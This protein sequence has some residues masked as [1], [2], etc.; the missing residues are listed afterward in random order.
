MASEAVARDAEVDDGQDGHANWNPTS[1]SWNPITISGWDGRKRRKR[2]GAPAVCA[3]PGCDADLSA[4]SVKPYFRRHL[5][6]AEH[7][8]APCIIA[9]GNKI[10][11][12]QQCGHFEG[13]DLFLGNNRSCTASLDRRCNAGGAPNKSKS[14]AAKQKRHRAGADQK[15]QSPAPGGRDTFSGDDAAVGNTGTTSS[16]G[17]AGGVSRSKITSGKELEDGGG[18]SGTRGGTTLSRDVDMGA[19]SVDRA[20]FGSRAA[21]PDARARSSSGA[22]NSADGRSAS[23]PLPHAPG[24]LGLQAPPVAA[25]HSLTALGADAAAAAA[26]QLASSLFPTACLPAAAPPPAGAALWPSVTHDKIAGAVAAAAAAAASAFATALG[27]GAGA[28]EAGVVAG[29]VGGPPGWPAAMQ[30]LAVMQAGQQLAQRTALHLGQGAAPGAP[31]PFLP[32]TGGF[33]ATA[34][35][36]SA[37]GAASAAAP[38]ALAAL[39]PAPAAGAAGGPGG[40]ASLALHPLLDV[41][42]DEA[43]RSARVEPSGYWAAREERAEEAHAGSGLLASALRE[44]ILRGPASSR[45]ASGPGVVMQDLAA[46]AAAG[47]GGA[48]GTLTGAGAASVAGAGAPSNALAML[49]S[50]LPAPPLAPHGAAMDLGALSAIDDPALWFFEHQHDDEDMLQAPPSPLGPPPEELQPRLQ[51]AG[52]QAP[53]GGLG[54]MGSAP[55]GPRLDPQLAPIAPLAMGQGP[56]AA[57]PSAD[58]LLAASTPMPSGYRVGEGECLV[59]LSFKLTSCTPDE[60]DPRTLAS[61]QRMLSVYDNLQSMEGYARPGCT[62]LVI[63]AYVSAPRQTLPSSRASSSGKGAWPGLPGVPRDAEAGGESRSGLASDAGSAYT[64][65][66]HLT[67]AMSSGYS[68]VAS[69]MQAGSTF[70]AGADEPFSSGQSW[71]TGAGRQD[72]CIGGSMTCGAPGAVEG[73]PGAGA[74]LA[75]AEPATGTSAG[76]GGGGGGV[77]RGSREA[78]RGRLLGSNTLAVT[79]QVM[80]ALRELASVNLTSVEMQLE[81][82]SLSMHQDG[83]LAGMR[84]LERQQLPTITAAS[85]AAVVVGADPTEVTLY[86]TGL[87]G[88][89]TRL[90]G[91]M[92]GA[93]LPL[94]ARP[95]PGGGGGFVVVTLPP[96]AEPGLLQLE[97]SVEPPSPPPTAAAAFLRLPGGVGASA[98]GT[99]DGRDGAVGAAAVLGP[100]YPLL[101]LPGPEAVA[102][103]Q[104]LASTLAPSSLRR[105]VVDAGRLLGLGPLLDLPYNGVRPVKGS[106]APGTQA[107][108]AAVVADG[109]TVTSAATAV[110]DGSWGSGRSEEA[111]A[112]IHDTL[113]SSAGGSGAGECGRALQMLPADWESVLAAARFAE[114]PYEQLPPAPAPATGSLIQRL[115]D[116]L[117]PPATGEAG[118]TRILSSV[119]G[120][121]AGMAAAA[122]SVVE[123][124]CYATGGASV[125]GG[126]A[127]AAADE[128]DPSAAMTNGDDEAVVAAVLGDEAARALLAS[129][130]A[131]LTALVHRRLPACI[132]VLASALGDLARRFPHRLRPELAPPL[133]PGRPGLLHAAARGGEGRSLAPLLALAGVLGAHAS[134]TAPGP[135][136]VTPLH[137]LALRPDAP[138]LL[139]ALQAEHAGLTQALLT[140]QSHDG[141][142]PLQLYAMRHLAGDESARAAVAAAFAAAAARASAAAAEVERPS[143][144]SA[145]QDDAAYA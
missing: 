56:A 33:H 103:V 64:L 50:A 120:S 93:F 84:V 126:G 76:D 45:P 86:G 47:G 83:S 30:Q 11:Y 92:H 29:A 125:G 133:P 61:V 3:V 66:S 100:A 129:S 68:G 134:L 112:Y 90:W 35:A 142:T 72:S 28:G 39:G 95:A 4:A 138:R 27:C 53:V 118:H 63:D 104:A 136:G 140:A 106:A 96:L 21:H 16:K 82:M 24:T 59:R 10:R 78:G 19:D 145:A 60:L 105:F 55:L 67:T 17:E 88:P 49:H 70:R 111:E 73:E 15:D 123:R 79:G 26:I 124:P 80:E 57:G 65:A 22:A 74:A 13:L 44:G 69:I 52:P 116:T 114:S 7:M 41:E 34:W 135:A 77:R 36:P 23:L 54:S 12:C 62:L 20:V 37:L 127:A 97:A 87:T 42:L 40:R 48:T 110:S 137:L 141:R 71:A 108:H 8:K 119:V 91:R 18:A 132:E 101:V 144:A 99:G 113:R 122:G 121:A 102:E 32:A 115:R 75:A 31:A 51:V 58:L 25:A 2:K 9:S 131:L 81:D 43:M 128:D 6:C 107:H 5:V 14:T 89:H 117:A 46:T 85:V 94:P 38:G 98:A 143:K 139:P 109:D 1:T 130:V